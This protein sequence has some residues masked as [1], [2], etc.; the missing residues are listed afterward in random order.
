VNDFNDPPA[1]GVRKRPNAEA[2]L[3]LADP[4]GRPDIEITP[5]AHEVHAAMTEAL[6]RDPDLYQ[7]NAELVHCIA[8]AKEDADG[9]VS[10]AP[11]V[12][13]CPA[14]W[15]LDRVSRVARCVARS[16]DGDWKPCTPPKDRVRGVLEQGEWAGLRHLDSIVETPF[17]RPD[18]S[19]CQTPGWDR[20]TRVLY[21]PN[22]AFPAILTS[23]TQ[24]DAEIAYLALAD[25]F[26]DFPYVNESH[27][28]ATV[29]AILT[30]VARPAIRGSIPCWGFDASGPRQGK[31]L[32]TDVISLI[33]TGRRA[34]R[35]TYP[36]TDEE[37]EKVLA[38]YAVM[39]ARLVPFDNVARPFGGAALDKVIT[40]TDTVDLRV[41]GSSTL[42]TLAWRSLV[43]ASGNGLEF[44]GDMLPRVL[45]PRLES[46][47]E[48]PEERAGLRD[49]RAFASAERPSL[50]VHALTI[51]RG[52]VVAG[53]PA[54]QVPRWGGF[55]EW[56]DLVA[57]AL[58]W[59]GAADPQGAR[60]GGVADD[61]PTREA[62]RILISH[63]SRLCNGAPTGITLSSALAILYPGRRDPHEPPDGYDALREA[64]EQLTRSKAGF[65]PSSRQLGD[66]LRR[67]R[68]RV[69]M[70]SCIAVKGETHGQRR[71]DVT[72]KS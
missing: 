71:W 14:S 52:Y 62:E 11:I 32:Q 48:R 44:R 58:V 65:A 39:G 2:T 21:A 17:L 5:R 19:V 51:V 68:N 55:D 33:A 30:L 63:W 53:R 49:L 6:R 31:S 46:M 70:G 24:T 35:M 27:R 7:R 36:E 4:D 42:R 56:V 10:G 34:S 72:R 29:A 61:D 1:T 64:V 57:H 13:A 54:Q 50:V 3:R 43:M 40:A 37:L 38:S 60:R 67:M 41:L 59:A 45:A 16:K 25:V 23:P 9:W 8:S 69:I 12:R 28:A 26:R 15:L 22:A 18:G 66:A 20:A 47:L